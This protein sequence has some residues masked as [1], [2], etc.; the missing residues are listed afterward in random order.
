VCSEPVFNGAFCLTRGKDTECGS[1][2]HMRDIQKKWAGNALARGMV[3]R[4]SSRAFLLH[5]RH[6][7][8]SPALEL[9]IQ[10][11]SRFSIK[12]FGRRSCQYRDT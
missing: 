12:D 10:L 2:K 4:E 8:L 9:V 11:K 5:H 3:A 1:T 7:E 6:S